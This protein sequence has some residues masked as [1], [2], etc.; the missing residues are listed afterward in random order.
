MS[1]LADHD[2]EPVLGTREHAESDELSHSIWEKAINKIPT[3]VAFVSL[4]TSR[5]EYKVR[6]GRKY[7][8]IVPPWL[9]SEETY[10]WSRKP[11]PF[12]VRLRAAEIENSA[13]TRDLEEETY[14]SDN[15]ASYQSAVKA[16]IDKLNAFSGTAAFVMLRDEAR[17]AEFQE[18]HV[19]P[20]T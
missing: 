17:R 12:M 18:R 16:V 9:T 13:F 19:R 14:D 4:Q 7:Q 15:D 2:Y 8:Y 10:A 6:R 1:A 11:R 20:A 5:E 3:C